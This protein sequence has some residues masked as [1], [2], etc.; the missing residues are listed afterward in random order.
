VTA[1]GAFGT[2]A[3]LAADDDVDYFGTTN[4]TQSDY[5]IATTSESGNLFGVYVSKMAGGGT[6]FVKRIGAAT[7]SGW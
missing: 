4:T 6:I 3:A 1:A 7:S 5:S 2:V